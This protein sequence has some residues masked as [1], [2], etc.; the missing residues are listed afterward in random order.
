MRGLVPQIPMCLVLS[1][2]IQNSASQIPI[3]RPLIGAL[4]SWYPT[5]SVLNTQRSL[6]DSKLKSGKE[7]GPSK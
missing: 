1:A 7:Q 3:D 5:M 6:P 4:D 2:C